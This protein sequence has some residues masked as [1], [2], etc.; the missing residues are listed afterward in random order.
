MATI[1]IDT[2]VKVFDIENERGELL[3]Q[4]RINPNDWNFFTR[5]DAFRD[6]IQTWMTEVDTAQKEKEVDPQVLFDTIKE[7]DNRI[8]SEVNVLFDDEN[9][10]DVVFGNQSVFNTHNGVSFIERFLTSI[11]PVIQK[12]MIE[13]QKKSQKRIEKYT[14]QVSK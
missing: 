10:S 3:G 6:K 8:K 5:A 12:C 14:S 1:K 7:Y 4:L 11:L 9:A 2:G 13:E